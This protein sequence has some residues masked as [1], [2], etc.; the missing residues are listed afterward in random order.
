M[1]EYLG[2]LFPISKESST[3]RYEIVAEDLYTLEDASEVAE[4]VRELFEGAHSLVGDEISE[5]SIENEEEPSPEDSGEFTNQFKKSLLGKGARTEIRIRDVTNGLRLLPHELGFGVGQVIPIVAAACLSGRTVIIEQPETHL[6]PKQQADLGEILASSLA[7]QKCGGE[8]SSFIIETHSIHILE[9]LGK[10]IRETS[11]GSDFN[12]L[13]LEP[14]EVGV[15]YVDSSN[16]STEG[17]KLISLDLL[18]DGMLDPQFPD[19]FF[20]EDMNDLF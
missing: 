10:I 4:D 7:L 14:K 1:N 5:Y 19:G 20:N 8:R 13:V 16:G 9:R 18:N 17:A 12:G 2:L 11:R 6:H 15:N 3:A